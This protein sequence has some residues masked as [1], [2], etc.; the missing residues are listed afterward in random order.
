MNGIEILNSYQFT[1]SNNLWSIIMTLAII[2]FV[3]MIPA[4]AY[5]IAINNISTKKFFLGAFIS[6]F[7]LIT[8]LGFLSEKSKYNVIRYEVILS[9]EV[10]YNEFTEKYKVIEQRGKIFI[11][12][13]KDVRS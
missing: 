9:D 7:C 2:F 13:E 4:F 3:I 8:F 11:I 10:N 1:Q 12:E 6:L 5:Y